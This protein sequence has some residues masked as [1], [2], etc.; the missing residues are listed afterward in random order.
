MTV[1]LTSTQQQVLGF[2]RDYRKEHQMP[3]TRVE[4]QEFF[5]WASANAAEEILQRMEKAGALRL[6]RGRSRG[7]IDLETV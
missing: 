3:P 1:T 6:T 4:I 5:G 2:I 7:I